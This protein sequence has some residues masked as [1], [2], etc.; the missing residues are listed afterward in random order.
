[1]SGSPIKKHETITTLAGTTSLDIWRTFTSMSLNFTRAIRATPFHSNRFARWAVILLML[2]SGMA[3][4]ANAQPV[5][6]S[7]ATSFSAPVVLG[8]TYYFESAVL[9]EERA[10][11]ILLPASYDTATDRRYP[12]IYMLDG[13]V[14]EDYHHVSGLVQFLT[15]YQLMPESILV[16][17]ANVDRYRDF[18]HPTKVEEENSRVPQAGGSE[19]FSRYLAEELKP[20]IDSQFRTDGPGGTDT[21]IGQSLG[22]LLATEIFVRKPDLFDNYLIVSPSLWWNGGSLIAELEA[23]LAAGGERHGTVY[24]SLGTEGD[25]MQAGA[26]RFIAALEQHAPPT[27]KWHWAPLPEET[28]ATILHRSLYRAFEWLYGETHPGL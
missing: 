12:V 25:E 28:H 13:A 15:A 18:T 10:Q 11:N 19:R 4:M 2:S 23:T 8:T 5:P 24:V 22:G 21:F 14:H 26:D 17:I 27:L 3:G 1:M 7:I 16:G 6:E 20:F 9:G